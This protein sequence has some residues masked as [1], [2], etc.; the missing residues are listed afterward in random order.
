MDRPERAGHQSTDGSEQQPA[1]QAAG[2]AG[3]RNERA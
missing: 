3:E 1:E 2:R